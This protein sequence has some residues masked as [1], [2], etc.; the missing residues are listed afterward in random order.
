MTFERDWNSDMYSFP[1]DDATAQRL[2]SGHLSPEDAPPGYGGVAALIRTVIGPATPGEVACESA[3]VASVVAAVQS[4]PLPAGLPRRTSMPSKFR[5]A[6]FAVVAP[7]AA[8]L[9]AGTAAAAAT[10]T[11][12]G[13]SSHANKHAAAGLAIASSHQGSAGSTGSSA[14]TGAVGAVTATGGSIPATGPANQHAQFGLCTAFLAGGAN[15]S[16]TNPPKDSSTAF[17]ALIKQNGGVAAT[18]SY[19]QGVVKNHPGDAQ[20]DN[21]GNTP[22]HG[23]PG[24]SGKANGAAGKPSS[25]GSSSSH[26][27]VTTPNSGGTG[28]ADTASGGASSAGSANA[29]THPS[30]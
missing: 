29:G 25:A 17:Q 26:A 5:V 14:G 9:A 28:T 16:T 4:T 27:R 23:K 8:I 3:V 10:G 30:N 1:L 19:C 20:A 22:P 12:P 18:T 7:M 24:D 11:L 2:L 6:K 13:Q 21:A 15:T